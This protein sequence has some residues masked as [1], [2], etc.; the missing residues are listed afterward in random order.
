MSKAKTATIAAI[1]VGVGAL[2]LLS[3]KRSS[4]ATTGQTINFGSKMKPASVKKGE[5]VTIGAYRVIAARR[6]N[7]GMEYMPVSVGSIGSDLEVEIQKNGTFT[8]NVVVETGNI[9][10]IEVKV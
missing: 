1:A 5:V 8:R 2:L 10:Y 7:L 9:V 6:P 4:V 3:G